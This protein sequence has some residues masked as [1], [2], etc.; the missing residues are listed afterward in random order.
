MGSRPY[1]VL[2]YGYDLSR[3][4]DFYDKPTPAWMDDPDASVFD[5]AARALMAAAGKPVAPDDYFDPDDL[6]EVCGV[7]L[8]KLGYYSDAP[9]VLATKEHKTDWN[10]PIVIPH[11][12]LPETDDEKLGWALGVLGIDPGERVPEW[13]LAS[14]YG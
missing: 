13:I 1:A 11:F 12:V 10:G 5:N 3:D 8:L 9:V 14:Y 6:G 4:F 2:A 7:M